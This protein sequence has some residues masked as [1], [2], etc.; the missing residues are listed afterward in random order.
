MKKRDALPVEG[1]LLMLEKGA[2]VFPV[3][4]GQKT[5]A[6]EEWQK[7]AEAANADKVRAYAKSN[8]FHNWGVYC[9][10]SDL[11]VID[12]DKKSGVDGIKSFKALLESTGP[13]ET[14]FT[15]RTPSGGIHLYF[16]GSERTTAGALGPGIDTRG[17]GG[18]VLAPLSR[19]GR[20][21]Y[22][23]LGNADILPLPS[24][25]CKLLKDKKR[26]T[27]EALDDEENELSGRRNDTLTS[28]AGT[29]RA[30]GLGHSAIE[31]A[32]LAVNQNQLT[33]PLSEDEVRTIA[34]S[35][36]RYSPSTAE[37]ASDFLATEKVIAQKASTIHAKNI[38][39]RDW[40]Q[41]GR[42][43]AGFLSVL[44]APGGAGKSNLSLLDA[45]SIALGKSLNGFEE[46]KAAGVW[47]YNTEDPIDEIRRRILALCVTNQ[48]K[49]SFLENLH[50]T[51]GRD[52]P[53]IVAKAG[54]NGVV[55]NSK[56][57]DEMIQYIKDNKIRLLM[58]D[59]FV[60]SHEVNENDNMQIDKVAWVFQRIAERASCS[61]LLVHHSRKP[62]AYGGGGDM[63]TAR[64]ASSLINAARIAHTLSPMEKSEAKS[65]GIS[66]DRS[67]WFVRLESA[68]ANLSAPAAS[69]NWF[70]K[71]SVDLFNGD[72]VGALRLADI[73]DMSEEIADQEFKSDAGD[74]AKVLKEHVK[75]GESIKLTDAYNILS[76]A[77]V[78]HLFE[79][80]EKRGKEKIMAILQSGHCTDGEIEASYLYCPD[81]YVKH[82]VKIS[83][84][85]KFLT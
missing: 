58:V 79:I 61:V 68:K 42:F 37:V 30:R 77:K 85:D 78:A 72:Q 25:F 47:V 63:N 16:K 15:V 10:A 70:E 3:S 7:W 12:L 26:K 43:I 41:K 57:M 84:L 76:G 17:K 33:E 28:I 69:A 50:I 80:S 21:S 54:R 11:T 64:G 67:A 39:P 6:F 22:E 51:S 34:A 5:P 31:A 23:P 27:I 74:V 4:P 19:I 66:P 62:G 40:V 49:P 75:P 35:V 65:F 29:M 82:R 83:F 60:R 8:P 32:L 73:K 71:V 48:I 14:T 38:T 9:G 24:A 44:I 1:A 53:L 45:M 36:A 81:E 59:P 56:A 18:Y 52:S 55:I 20:L 46:P 13:F 2:K